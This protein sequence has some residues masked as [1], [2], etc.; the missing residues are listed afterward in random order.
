MAFRIGTLDP[1]LILFSSSITDSLSVPGFLSTYSI[2]VF[3]FLNRTII[4]LISQSWPLEPGH[5]I[6][7]S[8]LWEKISQIITLFYYFIYV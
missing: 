7:L 4:G 5:Q 2:I 6:I 3:S 1:S 8:K